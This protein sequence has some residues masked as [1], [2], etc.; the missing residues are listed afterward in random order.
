MRVQSFLLF[1][2]DN[3]ASYLWVSLIKPHS[4]FG[5][6]WLLSNE[7]QLMFTFCLHDF[8]LVSSDMCGRVFSFCIACTEPCNTT[9]TCNDTSHT[10]PQPETKNIFEINQ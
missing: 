1:N 2:I 4:S 9:Q 7:I 8:D 6:G 3:N 5:R 10:Q